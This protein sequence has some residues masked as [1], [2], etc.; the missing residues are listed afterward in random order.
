M[1]KEIVQAFRK[2]R[3]EFSLGLYIRE[4]FE[5]T[6]YMDTL[7]QALGKEF[8]AHLHINILPEFQGLG[9][10]SMLLD[11]LKKHLIEIG[12]PGIYLGVGWENTGAIQF[13]E[14]TGFKLLKKRPFRVYYYGIN[15]KSSE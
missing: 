5:S 12:C 15:L 14:K 1:K 3:K 13:Y 2:K 9:L 11:V 7:P 10:G 6:R 4:Y 8:P